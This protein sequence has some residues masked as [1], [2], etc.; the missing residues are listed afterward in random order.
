M[1]SY[2]PSKV[3]FR[4]N[5]PSKVVSRLRSSS[6][7]VRPPSK[8]V[9]HQRSS[10]IKRLSSIKGRVPSKVVFHQ[11]SSFIKGRLPSKIIFHCMMHDAWWDPSC[12]SESS[13]Y[14]LGPLDKVLVLK[15]VLKQTN[16]P[17]QIPSPRWFVAEP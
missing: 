8:V 1:T 12:R 7:K 6:I 3:V 9:F 14:K 11:R 5:L 16:R 10:S 15:F 17:T 2:L 4:Q 13:N